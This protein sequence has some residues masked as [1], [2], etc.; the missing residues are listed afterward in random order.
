MK[1]ITINGNN[2]NILV[3]GADS[4]FMIKNAN[5]TLKKNINFKG[6]SFGPVIAVENGQLTLFK[7]FYSER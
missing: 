4:A 7:L 2:H 3:T 5:V 1:N 6:D